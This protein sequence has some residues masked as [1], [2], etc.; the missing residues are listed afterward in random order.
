MGTRAASKS[1]LLLKRPDHACRCWQDIPG[2]PCLTSYILEHDLPADTKLSKKPCMEPFSHF[3]Q[4]D[5]LAGHTLRGVT[6]R[7][8]VNGQPQEAANFQKRSC[9]ILQRDVL[10]A[11][12]TVGPRAHMHWSFSSSLSISSGL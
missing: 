6:G 11:T 9:Y 8:T 12:A 5:I 4:I 1:K 10:L 2:R 3:L 7:I